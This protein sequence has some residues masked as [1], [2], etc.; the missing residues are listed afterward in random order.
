MSTDPPVRPAH[1]PATEQA[2]SDAVARIIATRGPL[3]QV[4]GMLM[5]IYGIDEHAAFEMLRSQARRTST[6]IHVVVAQ[7]RADVAEVNDRDYIP[8]Q[9]VFDEMLTTGHERIRR[10][11]TDGVAHEVS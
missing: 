11:E 6:N 9:P 1:D 3:E 7:F 10:P 5:V 8:E 2:I 4:K